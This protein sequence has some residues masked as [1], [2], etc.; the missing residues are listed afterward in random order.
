ML[1]APAYVGAATTAQAE[2]FHCSTRGPSPQPPAAAQDVVE[3]QLTAN[4]PADPGTV[5]PGITF[6]DAPSHCSMSGEG[7][8]VSCPTA[9]QNDAPTQESPKR[10]PWS[11]VGAL[12]TV[13]F[14]ALT[15]GGTVTVVAPADVSPRG[16]RSRE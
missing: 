3:L 16:G 12:S 13:Q 8:P 10:M 5:G 2:P 11:T 1:V 14:D 15:V 4:S 9:T 6:H 7:L